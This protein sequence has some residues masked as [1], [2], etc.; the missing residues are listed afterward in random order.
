MPWQQLDLWD[1]SGRREREE[2]LERA[3][4]LLH[5][6]FPARMVGLGPRG[7]VSFKE[8]MLQFVDPYRW[9]LN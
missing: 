5:E 9:A 4:S 2:R 3:L 8:Q 7:D 6:R 1:D